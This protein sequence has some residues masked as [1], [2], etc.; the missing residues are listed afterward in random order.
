VVG[1]AQTSTGITAFLH[2]GTTMTDLNTRISGA[3]GWRLIGAVAINDKGLIAAQA[4]LNN[5]PKR[6]VLLLPARRVG[7]VRPLCPPS[8][9][10]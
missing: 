2:N 1:V 4:S 7:T 6:A 10:G 8:V 3:S 9:F 5:G